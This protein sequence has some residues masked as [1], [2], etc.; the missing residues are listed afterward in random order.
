MIGFDEAQALLAAVSRPASVR[1]ME[2][3]ALCL[4][5]PNW[6]AAQPADPGADGVAVYSVL[7]IAEKSRAPLPSA[8]NAS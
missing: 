3:L 7:M 6:F 4:R 2:C 1:V 5:P 8:V